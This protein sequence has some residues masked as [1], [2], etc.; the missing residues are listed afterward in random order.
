[1]LFGL[2]LF[3]ATAA[4]GQEPG[5]PAQPAEVRPGEACTIEGQV[6]KSTTSEGLRKIIVQMQLVEPS[7]QM[8]PGEERQN[9]SANTDANGHFLFNDLQPGRYMLTAS[10][11]GYPQQGYG[12]QGRRP[13]TKV[14]ALSPGQH[15]KGIVFR[16]Q[17]AGVITGTVSDEDGD[18]LVNAQVQ[19]LRI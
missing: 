11:N 19:A 7:R 15:E 8:I 16:L 10:G 12:Q 9:R 13:R 4:Q 3:P 6:V 1:F 2:F 17:P 14:L 5:A 18:P